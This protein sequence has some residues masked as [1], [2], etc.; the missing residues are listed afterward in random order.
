MKKLILSALMVTVATASVNAQ[1]AKN[2][3]NGGGYV[4]IGVGYTFPFAGNTEFMGNPINGTGVEGT[5]A[6]TGDYM[7]YDV[8]NASYGAG[9]NGVIGGGYM[10]NNNIGIDLA[11]GVGIAMKKNVYEETSPATI[12]NYSATRTSYAK[13]PILVM[14]SLVFSTGTNM[15]EGYARIGLALPVAGKLIIED[16]MTSAGATANSVIEIK[17]KISLGATGAVGIKYHVSDMIG[18]WIE[19]NGLSM[20]LS[21]KSGEYTEYSI[22]GVNVLSQM[23]IANREIEFS[24][25]Y[26][27]NNPNQPTTTPYQ[28]GP[29]TAPFSN[30][31]VGLGVSFQF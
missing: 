27:T 23:D 16:E 19:A 11:V 17:N 25:E 10:F 18:L 26:T 12:N 22:M 8:K 31:G 30:I 29:L 5:A 20:N 21:A 15:V 2:S 13:M 6:V 24:N 3:N 9:F 14:P 4:R 1:G 7:T 28:S